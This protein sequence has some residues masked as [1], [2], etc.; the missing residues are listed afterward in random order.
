MR[1]VPAPA[2][3]LLGFAENQDVASA[4]RKIGNR[5]EY[6]V[7]ALNTLKP[8]LGDEA[9]KYWKSCRAFWDKIASGQ[10]A[11]GLLVERLLVKERQKDHAKERSDLTTQM[12]ALE[13][14]ELGQLISEAASSNPDWDAVDKMLLGR[15]SRQIE[16]NVTKLVV[17]TSGKQAWP[18]ALGGKASRAELKRQFSIELNHAPWRD[19][20]TRRLVQ[21][22]VSAIE[23]W[24]E[25]N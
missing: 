17:V 20:K 9:A 25:P 18:E 24:P 5:V 12:Q 4:G 8:N 7:S 10:D 1:T 15:G 13:Q 23:V 16:G 14:S 3:G 22:S 2:L 19:R 11:V 6:D 21:V